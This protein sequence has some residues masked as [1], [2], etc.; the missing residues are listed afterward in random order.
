M[1]SLIVKN[2]PHDGLV[3]SAKKMELICQGQGYLASRSIL[4]S[5]NHTTCIYRTKWFEIHKIHPH[6]FRFKS[7]LYAF[8]FFFKLLIHNMYRQFIFI[9]IQMIYSNLNADFK[10]SAYGE[11]KGLVLPLEAGIMCLQM[12]SE[13]F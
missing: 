6:G 5:L 10:I 12:H 1:F 4:F 3:P 7:Q 9:Q 8:Y 11:I 13:L 2:L